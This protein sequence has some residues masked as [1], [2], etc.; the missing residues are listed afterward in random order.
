M[1]FSFASAVKH[2]THNL[3]IGVRSFF[4]F[5][6][7]LLTMSDPDKPVTRSQTSRRNAPPP[8][9][10]SSS[11]DHGGM[12][13]GA[14]PDVFVSQ[15]R[16]AAEAPVPDAGVIMGAI[17]SLGHALAAYSARVSAVERRLEVVADAD[18]SASGAC[19]PAADGP[20]QDKSV[21]QPDPMQ[22]SQQPGGVP[23]SS[24]Q[25]AV[26]SAQS[27]CT[28]TGDAPVPGESAATSGAKGRAL[29]SG[30]ARTQPGCCGAG[31]YT[32][33]LAKPGEFDGST[34]WSAFIA[35]FRVIALS[36]EWNQAD[37]LSV[38]VASL[39]GP[40]LQ[41]FAHLPETDQVDFCRLAGALEGR[42]GVANQEP[43]YRSQ[44]R[45]RKREAGETLP[46]L[47]QEIERLVVMAYPSATVA[48]RDSLSCDHFM[49]ALDDPEL[50]VAVRQGRPATLPQALASAV[51]IEAVRRA[52]GISSRLPGSAVV[53][54]QSQGPQDSATTKT[55]NDILRALNEL[56]K[57]L[58]DPVRSGGNRRFSV[59]SRQPTGACW[60]CGTVGHF[61]RHCP[62]ARDLAGAGQAKTPGN[63]Q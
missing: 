38:L 45:R 22:N 29:Q 18:N 6:H 24:T 61:R 49:D 28:S 13:D 51:E 8:T 31:S 14:S 21:V 33:N 48:L 63:G 10:E 16:V 12:V 2:L 50:H 62:R 52:A 56:Q 15:D 25:S 39:K 55:L 17:Q 1:F 53:A 19:A 4:S 54:R 58:A 43:W 34:S 7:P 44:L 27:G 37:K 5:S 9:E 36:Q 41:L 26:M 30:D 60:E 59:N 32:R 3:T 47:A 40:A 57:S 11:G 46:H 23:S 42:F 35:Q 20:A